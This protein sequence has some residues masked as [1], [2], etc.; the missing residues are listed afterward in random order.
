M[1][2]LGLQSLRQFDGLDNRKTLLDLMQRLGQGVGEEQA[3]ARRGAVIQLLLRRHGH[4]MAGQAQASPMT[5]EEAYMA[6]AAMSGVL[7]ADVAK[8]ACDL[9]RQLRRMGG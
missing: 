5:Q 3:C 1:S 8:L 6:L 7:G 2:V 9:E 4:P